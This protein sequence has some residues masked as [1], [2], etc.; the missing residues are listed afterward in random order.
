MRPAVDSICG[1]IDNRNYYL[2]RYA[3]K[4]CILGLRW[5]V[6]HDVDIIMHDCNSMELTLRS[7]FLHSLDVK[8]TASSGRGHRGSPKYIIYLAWLL[9]ICTQYKRP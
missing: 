2:W 6:C 3:T 8:L 7:S 5:L 4:S 1:I 9:C